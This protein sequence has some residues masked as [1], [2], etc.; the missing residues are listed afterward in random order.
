MLGRTSVDL[1]FPSWQKKRKS[2]PYIRVCLH[3][4]SCERGGWE[5]RGA[6]LGCRASGDGSTYHHNH[7]GTPQLK[8]QRVTAYVHGII[9]IIRCAFVVR[10]GGTGRGRH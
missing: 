3:P 9:T 10:R 8:L 7:Q 1:N 2:R 4:E 5:F 6:V